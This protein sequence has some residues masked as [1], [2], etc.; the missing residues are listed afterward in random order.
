MVRQKKE[1]HATIYYVLLIVVVAYLLSS[2]INLRYSQILMSLALIILISAGRII[3]NNNHDY[4][5]DNYELFLAITMFLLAF[6]GETL[7]LYS[8]ISG[9]DWLMHLVGG[10]YLGVIFTLMINNKENR[11]NWIIK[12]LVMILI[13]GLLWEGAEFLADKNFNT[14]MQTSNLDTI[15]DLVMAL[16]GG[17]ITFL[18][19]LKDYKKKPI[20][21]KK[22]I[23]KRI[24]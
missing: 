24:D 23:V 12:L 20:I 6:F 9:Y 2:I 14:M 16:I 11:N 1:A 13:I 18:V 4:N 17:M 21:R 5:H 8:K 22:I 10:L 15:M 3:R 7:K 19:T